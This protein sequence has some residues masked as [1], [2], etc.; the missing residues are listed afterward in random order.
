MIRWGF[1]RR[2]DG[3][4]LYETI[5]KLTGRKVESSSTTEPFWA[6]APQAAGIKAGTFV[7]Y[8]GGSTQ[9]DGVLNGSPVEV[10][11]A[12]SKKLLAAM[13]LVAR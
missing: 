1:P 10:T 5:C 2:P 12:G 9:V 13:G 4:P 7:R 8:N 11:A 6:W 3:S